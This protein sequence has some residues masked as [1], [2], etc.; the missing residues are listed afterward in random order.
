MALGAH[1]GECGAIE[2]VWNVGIDT[3]I[4]DQA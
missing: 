3:R 2:P 4:P 1:D